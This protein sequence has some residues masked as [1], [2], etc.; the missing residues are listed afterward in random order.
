MTKGYSCCEDGKGI[1]DEH[2]EKAIDLWICGGV[3]V[4]NRKGARE[5]CKKQMKQNGRS[6]SLQF[7]AS[8]YLLL[9]SDNDYQG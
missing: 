3:S 6:Y 8:L 9:S 4:Y 7:I 2:D 1:E 5:N